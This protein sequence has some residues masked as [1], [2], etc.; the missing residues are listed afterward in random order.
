MSAEAER[1]IKDH[2]NAWIDYKDKRIGADPVIAARAALNA[3][4]AGIEADAKRYRWLR[5][6]LNPKMA[7]IY[8]WNSD[9]PAARIM[10]G[11]ELDS[12][13]DTA[14]SQD[15]EDNIKKG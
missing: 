2:Q 13:L 1:L 5:A 9:F 12:A 14:V 6:N 10:I 3:F 15:T 8:L 4:I 7:E 11:S